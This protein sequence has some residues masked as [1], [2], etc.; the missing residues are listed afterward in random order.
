MHGESVELRAQ[1]PEGD[2]LNLSFCRLAGVYV[3]HGTEAGGICIIIF[4]IGRQHTYTYLD[5]PSWKEERDGVDGTDLDECII[6]M[7]GLRI[8]SL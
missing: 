7:D 8:C 1:V 6:A 4:G 2:T 3:W 5:E